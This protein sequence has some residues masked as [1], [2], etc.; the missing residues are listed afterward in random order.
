MY[1]LIL[2]SLFSASWALKIVSQID[3]CEP[4]PCQKHEI[5]VNQPSFM[6][7]EC[8]VCPAGQVKQ[9]NLSCMNDACLNF[10]KE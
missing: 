5:C 3:F 8:K 10:C 6:D 9:D 7:F 2:V 4:F 1:R